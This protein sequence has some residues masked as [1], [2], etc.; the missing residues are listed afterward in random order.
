MSRV[1]SR[2]RHSWWWS[3]NFWMDDFEAIANYVKIPSK[4]LFL[5]LSQLTTYQKYHK[6][7]NEYWI[8]I[9]D[10]KWNTVLGNVRIYINL[11]TCTSWTAEMTMANLMCI[12]FSV[13]ESQTF[14]SKTGGTWA[15]ETFLAFAN[16]YIFSPKALFLSDYY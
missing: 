13:L 15:L 4:Q 16:F 7:W 5:F 12:Y 11:V 9:K 3:K 10:Y 14:W 1:G 6:T 8:S 2:D